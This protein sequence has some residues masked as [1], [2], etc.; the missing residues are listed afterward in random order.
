M[1]GGGVFCLLWI[2]GNLVW[3][4]GEVVGMFVGSGWIG[5]KRLF[6]RVASMIPSRQ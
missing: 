3:G 4:M 2:D 6:I 5:R 1:D